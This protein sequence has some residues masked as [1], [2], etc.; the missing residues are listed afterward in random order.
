[1]LRIVAR[2]RRRAR[3]LR[4]DPPSALPPRLDHPPPRGAIHRIRKLARSQECGK[5]NREIEMQEVTV[6]MAEVMAY[7]R[8]SAGMSQL[9]QSM[10]AEAGP[11]RND[12]TTF[13]ERP[14]VNTDQAGFGANAAYIDELRVRIREAKA[15]S[16][17]MIAKVDFMIDHARFTYHVAQRNQKTY[18]TVV[19][20]KAQQT[21]DLSKKH[22][23]A[24]DG[25]LTDLLQTGRDY[26]DSE[27]MLNDHRRDRNKALV[28]M[29][30]AIGGTAATL[31]PAA[32]KNTETGARP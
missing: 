15:K 30:D 18:A 25:M 17:A 24:G 5:A 22:F 10:G 7:P 3:P 26:F 1:M 13:P 20:P 9:S 23:A 14:M 32:A 2:L 6:R 8:A 19:V 21:Y 28:D 16:D 31:L 27:K 4:L 12:M 11:T 29:Q